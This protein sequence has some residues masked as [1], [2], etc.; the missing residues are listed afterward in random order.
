MA[1]A[2]EAV[3]VQTVDVREA[4]MPRSLKLTGTLRGSQHT[5]LAANAFGRVLSTSVER[6]AEVKKGDRLA[7]LDVRSSAATAAEAR[8][9]IALARAQADAAK[10]ECERYAKLL[11]Q[12]VISAAE[13]DR[14]TDACRTSA[15]SVQAA[16][17]R[18]N[19]V[20]ILISDGTIVA[21]FAGVITERFINVGDYVR[22]D[23][24]V[25][26]LVSL[27][28]LRLEFTVPEAS[29][30]LVKEGGSLSFTVPAYPE[31]SFTGTVRFA[32]G[33]VRE[34]TRDTV[35]EAVVDNPDKVLRPGMFA[36][37]AL[38]T[39]E[40]PALVLPRSALVVKEDGHRH[41][42]AVVNQ[43]IEERLVQTGSE[44]DDL[45]SVLHGVASGDKIVLV[46]TDTLRN[47]QPV[48]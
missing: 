8:T 36:T 6:G 3:T 25:V 15:I 42:F 29:L 45:V 30:A 5:D 12:N 19:S 17:A 37:V 14:A 1:P 9:G 47:G 46:P 4:P 31:R 48:N 2:G 7:T 34:S 32:S 43:R 11:A 44:K 10:R 28:A 40:S 21:P 27:D 20:G 41:I 38:L 39:G 18:A 33:A 35:A 23:S 22:S 24:K 13:H 16:Q 26:S